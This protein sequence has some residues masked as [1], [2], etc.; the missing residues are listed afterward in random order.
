MTTLWDTNAGEIVKALSAERRAAGAVAFGIVL[1]LVVVVDERHVDEAVAAATVGTAAHPCRLIVVTRR[2]PD[3]PEPRLDAEV[4]VGGGLGTGEACILRMNGRLARHA[5]SVV[6][7][8]L[9]P[10]TPVVTYWF[11]APPQRIGQDPLG[12]LAD[13]RITDCAEAPDPLR[14][15]RE[16]AADYQP[17][18]T[19]L[20]WTRITD[21]RSTVAA[22]FD[23]ATEPA[24]S[25]RIAA[26]PDSPSATLLGAWM[27]DRLGVPMSGEVSPGPGITSVAVE[28]SGGATMRIERPDGRQ[29]TLVRTG[30][31]DRTLPLHRRPVGDLLAE[32]LRRLDADE[33]YAASLAAGFGPP[34]PTSS[35]GV[36]AG[37]GERDAPDGSP[38]AD[39]PVEQAAGTLR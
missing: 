33:I 29:A 23:S 1:T 5:E 9:A 28:F 32:E 21:W 13:R 22:A 16:R 36:R 15:L 4:R 11:G 6:L 25:A 35:R 38:D 18:D 27:G 2:L 26:E 24:T 8:L 30:Q 34:R 10:D 3:S 12:V 37:T 14:A 39:E 17:G 19:D 7:P 31:P 20:S